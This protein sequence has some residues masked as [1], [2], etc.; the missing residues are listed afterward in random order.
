LNTSVQVQ[1]M[2][3]DNLRGLFGWL[4]KGIAEQ[5]FASAIAWSENDEGDYDARDLIS[6]LYAFNVEQFP[7][8]SSGEHPVAAYEKKMLALK[9]FEDASKQFQRMAPIVTDIL[10]LHDIIAKEGPE[11]WNA[12]NPRGRADHLAW[13]DYRESRR[14]PHVFCFTGQKGD[15]RLFDGALY[16]M[17]AAYRWYVEVDPRTTKM[18]WKVPFEQVVQAFRE[19]DAKELLTA[20]RQKSDELGHNPNAIGKSR[21]HWAGLHTIVVKNDLMSRATR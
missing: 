2:S 17:L 18:R 20:T 3:L 15:K 13:V 16:P 14:R 8:D 11:I 4:K 9:E 12:A 6:L 7:N 5:P 19:R 10:K 21:P 1:D